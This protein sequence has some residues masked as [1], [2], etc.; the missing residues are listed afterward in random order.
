VERFQLEHE[1]AYGYRAKGESVELVNIRLTALTPLERPQLEANTAGGGIPSARK[2]F[3]DDDWTEA[4]VW[5]RTAMGSA[6]VAG[7]AVI[8]EEEATTVVP[9][10]WTA[11]LDEADNLWLEA[12]S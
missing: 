8:E 9:P 7:P 5:Q 11:R 6:M 12:G 1:R 10:G 3:F 4:Q 2:A